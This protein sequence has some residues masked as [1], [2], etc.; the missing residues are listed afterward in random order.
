MSTDT[1]RNKAT[2]IHNN[3]ARVVNL[4]DAAEKDTDAVSV[5]MDGSSAA[6]TERAIFVVKGRDH[7]AYLMAL[8]E[9]QG[10][11]NAAKPVEGNAP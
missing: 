9:R 3:R 4:L 7:I 6:D 5:F 10:L 1:A 8:L 2:S 11:L